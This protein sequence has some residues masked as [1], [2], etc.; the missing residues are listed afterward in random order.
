MLKD[1]QTWEP[2]WG[3]NELPVYNSLVTCKK[4]K[5]HSLETKKGVD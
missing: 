1:P 3:A 4:K 5:V 2:T